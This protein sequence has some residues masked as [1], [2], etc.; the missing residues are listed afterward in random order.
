MTKFTQFS[1]LIV[2]FLSVVSVKAQD[3]SMEGVL[4][5]K[6]LAEESQGAVVVEGLELLP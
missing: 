4:E 6:I 1:L 2:F 3:L 5:N